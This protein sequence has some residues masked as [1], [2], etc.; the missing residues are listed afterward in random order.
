MV[1]FLQT[2]PRFCSIF[3]CHALLSVWSP[4]LWSPEAGQR[5][6][7][8]SS[9]SEWRGWGWR[10]WRRWPADRPPSWMDSA[11]CADQ[12]RAGGHLEHQESRDT[13]E[14]LKCKQ[15]VHRLVSGTPG[16]QTQTLKTLF[17]LRFGTQRADGEFLRMGFASESEWMKLTVGVKGHFLFW[18]GPEQG[19]FAKDLRVKAG[20]IKTDPAVLVQIFCEARLQ[21]GYWMRES[22]VELVHFKL[23]YQTDGPKKTNTE[24][25]VMK[26]C[27]NSI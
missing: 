24:K 5:Q 10:R 8:H 13:V 9:G 6:P 20:V 27:G 23:L 18:V 21:G 16:V 1:Y 3:W 19:L 2:T 7:P 17:M 12:M 26:F 22:V 11:G 15:L 14:V 25:T 4:L